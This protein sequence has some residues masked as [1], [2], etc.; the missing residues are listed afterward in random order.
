MGQERPQADDLKAALAV[1]ITEGDLGGSPRRLGG[2]APSNGQAPLRVADP[3]P[4]RAKWVGKVGF[5]G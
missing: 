1:H 4:W 2:I 3:D 5:R